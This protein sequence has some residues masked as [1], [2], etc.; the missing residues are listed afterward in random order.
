MRKANRISDTLLPQFENLK[1]RKL[2]RSAYNVYFDYKTVFKESV[3]VM[4][5][6]PLKSAGTLAA[7]ASTCYVYQSNPD[8]R[9]FTD[10]LMESSNNLLQLSGLIRNPE[11]DREVQR[12]LKLNS[13]GRLRR[14]SL[15]LFSVVLE[16][17]QSATCDLYEKH[18][19]YTQARWAGLWGRVVDFGVLG[20]WVMLERA[21][22]NYDV[23]E[24]ELKNC[25]GD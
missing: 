3:A 24:E 11:S 8:E 17:G 6:N 5:K 18:C 4:R 10:A 20:H 9:S 19:S 12:L 22:L 21:M 25:P 14:Q 2:G 7:V 23:N 16:E 1:Q 13:E 15:G